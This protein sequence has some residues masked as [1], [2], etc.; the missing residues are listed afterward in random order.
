MMTGPAL[1]AAILIHVKETRRVPTAEEFVAWADPRH[2]DAR[3]RI[4]EAATILADAAIDIEALRKHF[5]LVLT[6]RVE[7]P[8][9][10]VVKEQVE[11]KV[12]TAEK[13]T[14][15]RADELT[16]RIQDAIMRAHRQSHAAGVPFRAEYIRPILRE[17]LRAIVDR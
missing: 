8:V 15:D 14:I 7:V 10:R 11:V 16:D 13:F 6:K 3:L 2:P 1:A 9:G 4:A 12:R 17:Y 5:P